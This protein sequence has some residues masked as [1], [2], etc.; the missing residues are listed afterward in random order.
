MSRRE[1]NSK[2]KNR[3]RNRGSSKSSRRSSKSSKRSFK[4][5]K[6]DAESVKKRSKQGDGNRDQI[7]KDSFNIYKVKDDNSIRI[8]PPTWDDAEHYAFDVYIHYGIG[9]DESSYVC[10]NKFDSDEE[11][12][13]CEERS[14]AEADGDSDYASSLKPTKRPT[15]Y[16]LDRD[17][18]DEGPLLWAMPWTVDRDL[19]AQSFD[20]RSGEVIPLDDPYDGYDIS[21]TR[22][23]KGR[24]TKYIGLSIARHSSEAS[25]DLDDIL[26]QIQE[27]PIPETFE[28]RE[29]D[30]ISDVFSGHSSK[31][32]S[33]DDKNSKDDKKENEYTWKEIHKMDFDDLEE[34]V[35][36]EKLDDVIDIKD[37]DKDEEDDLADAICDELGI[38]KPK[39]S[40]KDNKRAKDMR[41]KRS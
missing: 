5:Q 12:P 1:R 3:E 18:E 27:N 17:N 20:S 7:F 15:C 25:D 19:S 4:Y 24:N 32:N 36:D 28:I 2:E 37:Y 33:S 10:L 35:G 13:I 14:K 16:L 6:R 40:S 8:L 23:G 26:D 39:K 30:Y 34:L 22:K 41:S 11:C 38:G 29:A 21:F 31:K 9:P